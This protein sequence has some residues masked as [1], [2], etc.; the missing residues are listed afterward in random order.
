MI[1][2]AFWTNG[3][4]TSGQL[5]KGN[6]STT[7]FEHR[8]RDIW[9]AVFVFDSVHLSN[10]RPQSTEPTSNLPMLAVVF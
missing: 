3:M 1:V 6:R 9:K 10:E 5:F 4:D 2:V 8:S 7:K